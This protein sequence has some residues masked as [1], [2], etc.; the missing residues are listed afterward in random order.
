MLKRSEPYRRVFATR[1]PVQPGNAAKLALLRAHGV[2]N[3]EAYLEPL[4]PEEEAAPGG[5][6]P[7]V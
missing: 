6:P 1:T 5:G 3:P 2:R 4:P 7:G